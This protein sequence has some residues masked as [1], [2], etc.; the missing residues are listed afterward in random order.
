MKSIDQAALED[1]SLNIVVS[2]EG[3]CVSEITPSLPQEIKE[4]GCDNAAIKDVPCVECIKDAQKAASTADQNESLEEKVPF[5]TAVVADASVVHEKS[6]AL[7]S[8]LKP[9]A[10][11][12]IVVEAT[13]IKTVADAQQAIPHSLSTAA[14]QEEGDSHR[15]KRESVPESS[16]SKRRCLVACFSSP[17]STSKSSI[18]ARLFS[19]WSASSKSDSGAAAQGSDL[20]CT[21]PNHGHTASSSADPETQPASVDHK[22]VSDAVFATAGATACR[23]DDLAAEVALSTGTPDCNIAPACVAAVDGQ[24]TGAN[25]SEKVD[26]M[27]E[28]SHGYDSSKIQEVC[29]KPEGVIADDVAEQLPCDSTLHPP[30]SR[31]A[32]ALEFLFA[33]YKGNL[34]KNSKEIAP[35]VEAVFASAKADTDA[36]AIE[37]AKR[38][39]EEHLA[40]E[41]AAAEAA[42]A[43]ERLSQ[44]ALAAAR[45][46][47][48]AE[49]LAQEAE[50]LAHEA[51][52]A[53]EAAKRAE[54]ECI[55]REAAAA[56]E[57][58][59]AERQ[60]AARAEEEPG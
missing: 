8:M 25:A 22:P 29:C 5:D 2:D 54:E 6:A 46:A 51:A 24:V 40:C 4:K 32:D 38:A 17:I 42:K 45:R 60:A 11:A 20:G 48:E 15:M 47:E 50:R 23:Q 13:V 12:R 41:A 34:T 56:A 58:A 18:L 55:A 3:T 49:R 19:P 44:E 52:E 7:E 35:D 36:E 33:T 27:D 14:P 1:G 30:V 39:E 10:E 9:T 31:N 57:A 43:E 21:S 53:A 37:V 59:K 26:K 16:P 28:S